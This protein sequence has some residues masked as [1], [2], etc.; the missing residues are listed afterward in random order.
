MNSLS[1]LA[2][3]A[4]L[5]AGK[6]AAVPGR[7]APA[8]TTMTT[9]K[10]HGFSSAAGEKKVEEKV[11]DTDYIDG[12]LLNEHLEF[13]DDMLDMT[14]RMEESLAAL[15][16]TYDAKR[17]ALADMAEMV[18]IDALFEKAAS[19]KALLSSQIAELKTILANRRA[20]A[21]DAPDGT[22]DAEL[23]EGLKEVKKIIDD[24]AKLED[25]DAI[26][27]QRAFDRAVKTDRA[28]DPQHDW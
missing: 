14:L 6:S 4:A 1:I 9:T 5:L 22:S 17:Q 11:P 16:G 8:M 21:T 19:Q 27:K 26:R 10:F 12:H 23:R 24:A 20:Y 25:A 28:R 3:R 15:Q 13:M 7:M 2:R 18:E